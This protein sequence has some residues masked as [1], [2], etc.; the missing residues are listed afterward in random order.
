MDKKTIEN[1]K[2]VILIVV[3]AFRPQNLS[4]FGYKK[5][6]DK[7][8]KKIAKES[9]LFK[10]CF[11]SS[12]STA[13]SLMSMFTG[14]LPKNH[15]IIHQ[16]PYTKEEEIIKMQD[17]LKFWLPS[18]LKERGY[19]TNAIDWIGMWFKDGFD[20]Y[21]E[22]EEKQSKIKKFMNIPKVKR[23][24]LGVPNWIYQI[25]KK[26]IKT[27]ASIGFVPAKETMDLGISRIKKS[28]K[29]FFLFMHFWDTHFPFKT[30]KFKGSEKKDV[31][32]VLA[33]IKDK[34][35]KEYFKKRVTDINLYSIED[36]TEKYNESIKN[37]DEQIGRLHKF[38]KKKNLW[39]DT[40]LI[41]LGDHGT[42]L[43]EHG[44]YFSSSGLYDDTIHVP[45]IMHFPGLE[46]KEIDSF[47]QNTDLP[48]T[49][50]DY[51]GYETMDFDGTS[52]IE[53]IKNGKNMRDK[54]FFFDGLC[55][56]IKGVRTKKR[57][58]IIAKNRLC[59]LCKSFHHKEFE[60]YDLEKDPKEN[61]N[62]YKENSELK[63]FIEDK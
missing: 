50:L 28:Q 16:F 60:E 49:I 21:E 46:S 39:E 53:T 12:N 41:I 43:T 5:E 40:I 62:V 18:Y 26:M 14:M 30:T 20:Y 1:K 55:E 7:N 13:P 29:P 6:T 10:Q 47:V 34:S 22:K 59:N 52:L 33:N 11:S 44:I 61:K 48:P 15:G 3:D 37:V 23:F 4:M 27:R 19:E 51:L 38:L 24:L 8:L 54:V 58:L 36:M 2:N 32:E 35:Q 17:N 56:D 63:K 25:G 45:L 9:V 42:N 57:K 31:D